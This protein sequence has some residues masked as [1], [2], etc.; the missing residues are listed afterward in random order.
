MVGLAPCWS[1]DCSDGTLWSG[2]VE[3]QGSALG[4]YM[5]KGQLEY[6]IVW[7]PYLPEDA[8]YRPLIYGLD[9]PWAL[10]KSERDTRQDGTQWSQR[11]AYAQDRS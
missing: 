6:G 3:P 8:S 2:I 11:E 1:L 5:V 9:T 10:M 4:W 7:N